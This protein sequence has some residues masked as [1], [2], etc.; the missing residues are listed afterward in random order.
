M[1]RTRIG[2]ALVVTTALISG[3]SIFLN[4]YAVRGFDSSVFVFAK[5]ALVALLLGAVIV[6][7]R[8]R[9]ELA[10]LD[11]RGWAT[12]A[13]IGLVGGSVPFLLFY[14]G[15]SLV[16][17][18]AA[19]LIHK[20]LFVFVALFAALF[21]RERVS[22]S[23]VLGGVLILGGTALFVRT[24][25]SF[26]PADLYVLAATVLWAAENVIAKRATRVMS[27]ELVAFGRMGFGALFIAGY[28][29]VLGR[30]P[31]AWSMSGAQ[32]AW[33]ALTSVFLLGYVWTFYTGLSRIRVSTA[34]ALL[35][36]GAPITA[37]LSAA[38][39][40]ASLDP[41]GIMAL[42][43]I[44]GGSAVYVARELVSPQPSRS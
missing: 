37:V 9:R 16:S 21:L 34:A 10:R 32:Y 4:G 12:L 43:L 29:A 26:A 17:G 40:T 18:T 44:A 27:G 41:I 1:D 28:L 30:I 19:G 22:R 35:T 39:G 42:A 3:I 15:L 7:T 33:I 38:A 13:T 24:G 36:L 5:S 6:G 11:V 31:L 14:R 20:S 23:A 25:L 8:K 2:I